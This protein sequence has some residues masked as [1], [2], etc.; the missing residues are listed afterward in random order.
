MTRK[1]SQMPLLGTLTGEELIP[2]VDSNDNYT[3]TASQL[4]LANQLGTAD[5]V[6]SLDSNGKIPLIQL[7]DTILN[8]V[9]YK[10]NRDA[11]TDTPALLAPEISK[12]YYY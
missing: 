11:S 10:G 6:A 9:E 12:G 8:K 7:D 4:L 3:I 2:D 1:I 5:G